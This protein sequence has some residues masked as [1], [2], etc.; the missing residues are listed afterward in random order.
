MS[1]EKGQP[2][3]MNVFLKIVLLTLLVIVVNMVLL[4]VFHAKDYVAVAISVGI[5]VLAA[6]Y[7]YR[8]GT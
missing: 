8:K 4:N 7:E 3:Q 5:A 2:L 1:V 6:G